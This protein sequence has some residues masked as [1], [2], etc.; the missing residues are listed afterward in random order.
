M[1]LNTAVRRLGRRNARVTAVALVTYGAIGLLLAVLLAASIAPALAGI[2]ALSRSSGDARRALSSTREAFDGFAV[3]LVDARL[4]AER[5]AAS[6]RS[7]AATARRLADAMSLSVFGA[8][9][10]LPIA[11]DF[12]RQ[13]QDLE[14]LA[15]GVDALAAALS[16][17]ELDVR[18]LR[19]DVTVLRDRIAGLD[20]ASAL[21]AAP[22]GVV[23]LLVVAWFAAMALAILAAGIAL[24]RMAPSR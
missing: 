16:A 21:Q 9:P 12:R 3:S 1:T 15:G 10:L 4:A 22:V 17:N 13:G 23:L 6:A 14:D 19:D 8:Q 11:S 5:A 18:V 2:D 20:S 24:W 7:S